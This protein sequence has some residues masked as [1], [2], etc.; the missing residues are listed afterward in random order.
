MKLS[1]IYYTSTFTDSMKKSLKSL[2]YLD[3][4]GIEIIFI[5]SKSDE[6]VKQLLNTMNFTNSKVKSCYTFQNLGHSYGYN[7]ALS[8]ARGKYVL[9]AGSKN[10]FNESWK[11]E[12]LESIEKSKNVDIFLLDNNKASV[13]SKN[14]DEIV[15]KEMSLKHFIFRKKFLID[16]EIKFEDFHH[17]HNLFI[18][19]CLYK[20]KKIDNIK[21]S[22]LCETKT[23]KYT[24]NLYDILTSS[25]LLYNKLNTIS[26]IDESFRQKML[27]SIASSILYEFLYKIYVSNSDNSDVIN[28]AIN[29]ANNAINKI[30]PEYKSN[31]FLIEN[32]DKKIPKYLLSFTPSI[33]YIKNE[34]SKQK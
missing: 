14:V 5:D 34:F 19:N 1:I 11:K 30:Y 12:V 3:D 32:K 29:N 17:Y 20:A 21:L 7:L 10:I 16:N 26:D 4:K 24:Y 23:N 22:A 6:N 13:S 8:E 15:L 9:F 25:E 33:K 27:A 18:F 28:S 2:S 31:S